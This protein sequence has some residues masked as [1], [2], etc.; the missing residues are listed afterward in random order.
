MEL[1][2]RKVVVRRSRRRRRVRRGCG[3]DI[4]YRTIKMMV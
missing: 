3:H 4:T 2:E 1:R